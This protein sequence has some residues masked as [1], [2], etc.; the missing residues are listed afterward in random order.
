MKK[1][2]HLKTKVFGDFSPYV[3]VEDNNI[4]IEKTFN[5]IYL[6]FPEKHWKLDVSAILSLLNFNYIPGDRTLIQGVC[7]MPWH[8]Y[9]DTENN[10]IR[11]SPIPHSYN[12]YSPEYIADKFIELLELEF[13]HEFSNY[14]T[15]W[16][17]QTGGLDSRVTLAIL[18]KLKNEGKIN[19]NIHLVTWGD[20]HSRDV[21]YSKQLANTY[22]YS[23]N[24]ID[25]PRN[26]LKENIDIAVNYG[27][28][29]VSA[30]HYH[31]E[32]K[33]QELVS[34]NDCVIAS[35]YGDS[36]GRAEYSSVH[37]TDIHLEPIGNLFH[38]FNPDIF[39][40]H[41]S[42][43]ENDRSHAWITDREQSKLVRNELDMQENYMR[44]MIAH[45]MD[46]I[47]SYTTLKQAFISERLVSFVFSIS[48]MCRNF[49]TYYHIFKNTDPYLLEIP[50]AR[51]GV[52]LCNNY[53]DTDPNHKKEYHNYREWFLQDYYKDVKKTLLHGKLVEQQIILKT[54]LLDVLRHW[55]LDPGYGELLSKLYQIELFISRYNLEVDYQFCRTIQ[56]KAPPSKINKKL[57]SM[58]SKLK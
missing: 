6:K 35:S 34:Q 8:S 22:N 54:Q 20:I 13:I 25:I 49:D 18:N 15:L 47:R 51:T 58:L 30:F 23:W 11:N 12:M 55:K 57:R 9:I 39:C 52:S 38:L 31:G 48:P 33:L 19:A 40:H 29:E 32:Y 50:W 27:A 42:I 37:L 14:N 17:L 16:I 2:T 56:E 3:F 1:D 43:I 44:R 10:I 26:I 4:Y 5:D 36:I 28:A 7:R 21:I 24:H 46:Y 41:Q 45:A 53:I